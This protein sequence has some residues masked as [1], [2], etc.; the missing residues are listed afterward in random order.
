MRPSG[1]SGVDAPARHDA[2]AEGIAEQQEGLLEEARHR[3]LRGN[4][5]GTPQLGAAGDAQGEVRDGGDGGLVDVS[6]ERMRVRA[7]A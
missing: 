1:G 3:L 6:S 7:A 2:Q 4:L 5:V